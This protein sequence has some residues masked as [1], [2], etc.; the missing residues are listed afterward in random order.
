M[1]VRLGTAFAQRTQSASTFIAA[2]SATV[3]QALLEMVRTAQ[4]TAV[5]NSQPIA[6]FVQKSHA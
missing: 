2:T 4:V 5:T 3:H 1:S 6:K